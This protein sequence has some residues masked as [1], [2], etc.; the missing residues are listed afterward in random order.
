M[1]CDTEHGAKT[2]A[3]FYSIAETA[4]ANNLKPY[5]YIRYVLTKM[6]AARIDRS[7][8]DENIIH[9]LLLKLMPWSKD[10]PDICRMTKKK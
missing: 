10:L 1:F 5:E 2:S 3:L 6:A 7:T 8:I 9:K 4:K